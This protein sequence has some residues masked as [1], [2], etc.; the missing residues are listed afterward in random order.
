MI[1]LIQ[2]PEPKHSPLHYHSYELNSVDYK[3][4]NC[5]GY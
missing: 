4:L 5:V 1:D 2:I 3:L